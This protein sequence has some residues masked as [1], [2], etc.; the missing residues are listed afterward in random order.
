[1]KVRTVRRKDYG[2]WWDFRT[3]VYEAFREKPDI[4]FFPQV[5]KCERIIIENNFGQPGSG[6]YDCRSHTQ[7]DCQAGTRAFLFYKKALDVLRVE[8]TLVGEE[9]E[10]FLLEIETGGIVYASCDPGR[11]RVFPT[12]MRSFFP[13]IVDAVAERLRVYPRVLLTG[14][15]SDSDLTRLDLEDMRAR[16]DNVEG[17]GIV[18]ASRCLSRDPRLRLCKGGLIELR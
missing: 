12:L 9:E 3:A 10:C 2:T 17:G 14:S 7:E 11:V 8:V 16:F 4:V 1:M 18:L 5:P 6:Y 15:F 13:R